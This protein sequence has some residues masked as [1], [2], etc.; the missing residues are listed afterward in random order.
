VS[1]NSSAPAARR[2][3]LRRETG[4]TEDGEK[5]ER[6]DTTRAPK[7]QTPKRGQTLPFYRTMARTGHAETF[8][9]GAF[10]AVL[11]VALKC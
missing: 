4:A 1:A 9:D 5:F 2:G 10:A 11:C 7:G 6:R 8:P 3:A